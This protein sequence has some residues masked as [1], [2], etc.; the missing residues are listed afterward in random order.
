MITH[1]G[2]EEI[3]LGEGMEEF[4]EEDESSEPFEEDAPTADDNPFG[5]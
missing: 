5:E 2:G 1:A 4:P 3:D